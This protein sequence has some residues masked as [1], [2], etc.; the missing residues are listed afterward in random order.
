MTPNVSWFDR[1]TAKLAAAFTYPVCAAATV[2]GLRR[3]RDPW[4]HTLGLGLR[5]EGSKPGLTAFGLK[6]PSSDVELVRQLRTFLAHEPA[7]HFALHREPDCEYRV[8]TAPLDVALGRFN[9]AGELTSL[10]LPFDVDVGTLSEAIHAY[11]ETRLL[12]EIERGLQARE[13]IRSAVGR[14]VLACCLVSVQEKFSDRFA[15]PDFRDRRSL[16][17]GCLH[18]V[19]RRIAATEADCWLQLHHVGGDGAAMQEMLTRLERSWGS[20]P[21]TFPHDG[22]R[23]QQTSMPGERETWLGHAFV[24][25]QPLLALR[26]RLGG[27]VPVAALFLWQLAQQPEFQGVRFANAV[28][29]P[30]SEAEERAVDLISI[31]PADFRDVAAFAHEFRTLAIAARERRTPTWN[32]MRHVSMLPNAVARRVMQ[33]HPDLASATFG[34]VGL[35][36]LRDAK[37]ILA[38]IADFDFSGGFIAIGNLALPSERGPVACVSMKGSREQVSGI[39]LRFN[40]FLLS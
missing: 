10:D 24:D 26:D 27:E 40:D 32:T 28:D 33:T 18:L 29:V 4:R 15:P 2:L 6:S 25:F 23:L 12:P 14:R 19:F 1:T 34:T 37:I 5:S 17:L 39:L 8:P 16:A 13:R 38:P 9:D 20:S 31:R 30:A 22:I 21:V 3:R 7:S 35:T 11:N 36:M